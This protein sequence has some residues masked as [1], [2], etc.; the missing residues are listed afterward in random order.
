M[1]PA[2]RATVDIADQASRWIGAGGVAWS[3]FPGPWNQVVVT[4]SGTAA[5]SGGR[6]DP[7]QVPGSGGRNRSDPGEHYANKSA[8]K[9]CGK[10][11]RRA[12]GANRGSM[13]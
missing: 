1:V 5:V 13:L 7:D 4:V 3:G 11:H 2:G 8:V 9:R 6:H 10:P 12:A